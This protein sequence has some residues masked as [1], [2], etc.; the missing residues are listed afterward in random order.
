MGRFEI[1]GWNWLQLFTAYREHLAQNMG[2]PQLLLS[3]CYLGEYQLNVVEKNPL[4]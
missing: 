1:Q 4:E 2:M 3:N